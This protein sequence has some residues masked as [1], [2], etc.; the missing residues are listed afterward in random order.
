MIF[1]FHTD[2]YVLYYIIR[3]GLGIN[4]NARNNADD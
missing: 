3:K 2:R 1:F 4:Y